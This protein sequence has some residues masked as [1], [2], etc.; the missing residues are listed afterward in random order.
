MKTNYHTHNFRCNHAVGNVKDYIIEAIKNEYDEIGLSDH[1]PHPGKNIDNVSRMKYEELVEY[2]KEI[3]EAKNKYKNEIS[4]MKGMECE[5]FE[6]YDWLYKEL[7]EKYKVEY[8]ILGVHF[9][10]YKNKWYYVGDINL[11][12]ESLKVYTDYVIKSME[13]RKF[14]YLAHPD[15]FGISYRNWDENTINASRRILETA[16]KLDMP[17]EININGIRRPMVRYNLGERYAYPI[18][19]FWELSKEYNVKRI[20]GVD[21]HNPLNFENMEWGLNFVKEIKIDVIEKLNL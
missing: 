5:Y 18:K 16:E 7:R 17:I 2:F 20:I 3:D 13:S 11:N 6:D 4:I 21:A 15:L 9:F 8:L 1:M 19:E 10:P 14:D 12:E